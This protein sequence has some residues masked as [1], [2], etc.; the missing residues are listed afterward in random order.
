M[1]IEDVDVRVD[2][3]GSPAAPVRRWR[4][5]GGRLPAARGDGWGDAVPGRH[6]DRAGTG[7]G[8]A[9]PASRSLVEALP[10]PFGAGGHRRARPSFRPAGCGSRCCQ[11]CW[12]TA[13][14]VWPA[15]RAARASSACFGITAMPSGRSC[16]RPARAAFERAGC[17]SPRRRRATRK[18]VSSARPPPLQQAEETPFAAR[19]R[20]A[21]CRRRSALRRGSCGAGRRPS[22]FPA[23]RRNRA[24]HFPH[25]HRR[26]GGGRPDRPA[27]SAARREGAGVLLRH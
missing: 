20:V 25:R 27:A 8:I 2:G 14:A 1:P 21:S 13:T 22:R 19:L 26:G 15:S 9:L 7:P 23:T 24:A 3:M 17:R 10:A 16:R 4:G 5:R 6:E 11:P 18:P 12:S